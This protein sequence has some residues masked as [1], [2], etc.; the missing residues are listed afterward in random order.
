MEP[1]IRGEL[2]A[3]LVC[4]KA[5]NRRCEKR[6]RPICVQCHCSCPQRKH[7]AQ[8]HPPVRRWVL[9]APELWRGGFEAK[10]NFDPTTL[11]LT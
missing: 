3:W 8:D 6:W 10:A 9:K 4:G 7:S 11:L 1:M 5:Q 2:V